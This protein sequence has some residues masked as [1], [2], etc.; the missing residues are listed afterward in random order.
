LLLVNL[1]SE[2]SCTD[3]MCLRFLRMFAARSRSRLCS[4]SQ[5]SRLAAF[6][7]FWRSSLSILLTLMKLRSFEV[8]QIRRFSL[9]RFGRCRRYRG[10]L[11][12]LCKLKC[13]LLGC[14]GRSHGSSALLSSALVILLLGW[15]PISVSILKCSFLKGSCWKRLRGCYYQDRGW[16]TS[17][18]L[19][20]SFQR[21][22]PGWYSSL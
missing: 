16:L 20:F 17:C 10:S 18:V 19:H 4:S 6:N 3:L 15:V 13:Q 12:Q 22:W 7:F 14:T 2:K 21:C 9:A 8:N 11:G 5:M 1:I